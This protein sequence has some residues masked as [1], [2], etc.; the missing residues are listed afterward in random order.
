MTAVQ[1]AT[2]HGDL[3]AIIILL[4]LMTLM[5]LCLFLIVV[6]SR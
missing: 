5:N 1:Y 4:C 6:F 2:V 3:T